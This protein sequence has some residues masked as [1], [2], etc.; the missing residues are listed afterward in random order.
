[1]E[2]T[3][4]PRPFKQP[5]DGVSRYWFADNAVSTHLVN[6]LNL[7]FPDGERFFVRAVRRFEKQV[8]DPELRAQIRHFY[9]Q[10]VRHAHAHERWFDSLREQGYP[11]DG[12][13]NAVAKVLKGPRA[14]QR[15]LALSI[16]VAL[17]HYT[18]VMADLVYTDPYFKRMDP[19]MRSLLMWHAAEE[20]EHKAVAFDV[21]K[22]LRPSYALRMAGFTVA[23]VGLLGFWAVGTGV[24]LRHD[25]LPM[26]R[27]LRDA[28]EVWDN[29]IIGEKI[30]LRALRTY[31][32]ADFHPMK[33][34]DDPQ[35]AEF[36]KRFEEELARAA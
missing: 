24:L 18:A 3:F 32:A 4:H 1:M 10:E 23:T 19:A 31:M 27:L 36:L 25:K 5:F 14:N 22:K 7:F 26:R 21:M 9:A 34:E 29:G 6:A 15:E 11:I 33:L 16:T 28:R 2:R 8:E 30:F 13:V 17:E 12:M 20:I 35:V